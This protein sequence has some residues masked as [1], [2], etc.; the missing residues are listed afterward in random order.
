[1]NL[2]ALQARAEALIPAALGQQLGV[3]LDKKRT[4]RGT[5]VSAE[6]ARFVTKGRTVHAQF[7]VVIE[8]G[9]NKTQ[10]TVHITRLPA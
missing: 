10:H 6:F 2:E 8:A 4:V 5:V 3:R 9:A 7:K 1:V